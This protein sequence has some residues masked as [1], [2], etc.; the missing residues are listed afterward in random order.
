MITFKDKLSGDVIIRIL[1]KGEDVYKAIE[2]AVTEFD[3][4]SAVFNMIGAVSRAVIGYFDMEKKDYIK[5]VI[6]KD[7]EL[8]SCMGNIARKNDGTVIVHAHVALADEENKMFGGHL[9]PGTLAGATGEL[10]IF[11]LQKTLIRDIDES[12]NLVLIKRQQT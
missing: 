8:V 6:E 1:L 5:K 9:F 10:F 3:I 12:T 2:S 4:K 11:P 7:L